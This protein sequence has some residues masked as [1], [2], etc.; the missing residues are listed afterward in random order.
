MLDVRV[1]CQHANYEL[2]VGQENY[3]LDQEERIEVNLVISEKYDGPYEV[4]PTV[5]KQ[6]LPTKLKT[7]ED[8]LTVNSVPYYEVSNQF[9]DTVYIASEV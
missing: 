9:G 2:S 5:D 3:L 8:D 1:E 7:M 4:T 6:I